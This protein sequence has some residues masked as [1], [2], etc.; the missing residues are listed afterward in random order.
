VRLGVILGRADVDDLDLFT[1]GEA[2]VEFCG[3]DQ[4]RGA[5]DGVVQGH[6]GVVDG[7]LGGGEGR[8]VGE[9]EVE[10][11]LGP[12]PEGDRG[13]QDVD[14]LVDPLRAGG[15]GAEEAAGGA[16]GDGLD[17]D[18]APAEVGGAVG[19]DV[20]QDGDVVALGPGLRL[21]QPGVGDVEVED[22]QDPG[23]EDAAV[24]QGAAGDDVAGDAAHLVRGRAERS[25]QRRACDEGVGLG[26]VADG[27]HVGHGG[28]HG[29]VDG[30]SAGRSE[31]GAHLPGEVDVRADADG[32]D[33]QVRGQGLPGVQAHGAGGAVV[34]GLDGGHARGEPQGDAVAG[35]GLGDPEAH[36]R[37]E[38]GHHLGQAFDEGD[39]DAA[40]GELLGH[41]QADE[42]GADDDGAP[43]GARLGP[44]ADRL[45]VAQVPDGEDAR[46]VH[47]GYRRD[48]A[49]RA[50]GQDQGVVAVGELG[51][52]G[53][54]ADRE[55][56]GGVVDGEDLVTGADVD[57]VPRGEPSGVAGAQ[58]VEVGDLGAD[59]V[60]DAAP[61]VGDVAVLL[62]DD[63]F[64]G[65]VVA[66]RLRPDR[67]AGRDRSDDDDPAGSGGPRGLG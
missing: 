54:V 21:G 25:P 19:L 24:G 6:A 38:G 60:G 9:V 26:G 10:Q 34:A 66:A 64:D 35:E 52:V 44:G 29:V 17:G 61:G 62:V 58:L 49:A 31:V 42:A 32:E 63:D 47:A 33:H 67:R 22:S 51:A 14:P 8:C 13:G 20:V 7:L 5:G 65:L 18:L 57:A 15:L 48:D 4:R 30:D 45:G 41:L 23:A 2:G 16:V 12:G 56:A 59:V 50:G 36:I 1:G 28:A 11:V 27:I 3:G 55:R 43:R 39:R 53:Q 40:A 46:G 37:I